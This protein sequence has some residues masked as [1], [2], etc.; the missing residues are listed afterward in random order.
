MRTL[1]SIENDL[2]GELKSTEKFLII[3]SNNQIF[4]IFNCIFIL[5]FPH[6]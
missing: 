4:H 2:M 6:K 5:N 3:I 1:D